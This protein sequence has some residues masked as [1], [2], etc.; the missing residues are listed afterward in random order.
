MKTVA[1]K[2]DPTYSVTVYPREG[3]GP[4]ASGFHLH[5]TGDS[6]NAIAPMDIASGD[7]RIELR[8]L[9]IEIYHGRAAAPPETE[10]H[11]ILESGC[12][13]IMPQNYLI[14]VNE[15]G[16]K[17]PLWRMD[18]D[19]AAPIPMVLRVTEELLKYS[20]KY[21]TGENLLRLI[22]QEQK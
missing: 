3:Y 10:Q 15:R 17:N 13:R 11:F 4:L 12:I 9:A 20:A 16:V 1:S 21:G 14:A 2:I 6:G 7:V 8:E 18:P 5:A 22:T 19:L